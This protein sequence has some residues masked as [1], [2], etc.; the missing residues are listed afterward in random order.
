MYELYFVQCFFR[1]TIAFH[2]YHVFR[3]VTDET[4][5]KSIDS[6]SSGLKTTA[7]LCSFVELFL[8][9]QLITD[10]QTSRHV[11]LAGCIPTVSNVQWHSMEAQVLIP[12]ISFQHIGYK[13]VEH[14][15]A[16][17]ASLT[18]WEAHLLLL[19]ASQQCAAPESMSKTEYPCRELI[20]RESRSITQSDFA[21]NSTLK[22]YTPSSSS[23]RVLFVR[24]D[25]EVVEFSVHYRSML[26]SGTELF[27]P[28]IH[29]TPHSSTHI[30]PNLA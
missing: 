21:L 24:Y 11:M 7:P 6:I 22:P 4:N 13:F 19:S 20:I 29:L 12:L 25:S 27:K 17:I 9:T 23:I 15:W 5:S 1:W 16:I 18:Y 10:K 2:D 26:R 30:P 3:E 28:A 8:Q 14:H